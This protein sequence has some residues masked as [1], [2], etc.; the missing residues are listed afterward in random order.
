MP[1]DT[2]NAPASNLTGAPPG[3]VDANGLSPT[4]MKRIWWRTIPLLG[5]AMMLNSIDRSNVSFA[6]L[7][8]NESLGFSSRV[9]GMGITI[10]FLAY[11]SMTLPGNLILLK[12]GARLWLGA[13]AIGWG[14]VSASTAFVSTAN[15]FYVNR[16]LLGL[17]EGGFQPGVIF[18]LTLWFPDRYRAG[19]MASFMM[20]PVITGIFGSP[21]SASLLEVQGLG[22]EGWQWLFLI[23]GLPSVLLGIAMLT[24]L[25]DKPETAGWM[26]PADRSALTRALEAD[27]RSDQS[28]KG[29]NAFRALMQPQIQLLALIYFLI[30]MAVWT[31][32][33]WMPQIIQ[34]LTG[35]GNIKT[36][37][38]SA[39][40]Y[41]VATPALLFIGR[42]SDRNG[43]RKWHLAGTLLVGAAGLFLTAFGGADWIVMAGL[44]LAAVGVFAFIGPFWSLLSA[45][46]PPETRAVVI[47]A[48]GLMGPLGGAIGPLL[49]GWLR[50]GTGSF[51]LAMIA[52]GVA[53]AAAAGCAL[54]ACRRSV[55]Q[56]RT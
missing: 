20:A 7:D 30:G 55:D 42:S 1:S 56:G 54:L 34:Q 28:V 37:A 15:E 9:F 14:T 52:C 45:L 31:V 36:G 35:S 29:G 41:L 32:V 46:V 10:F 50:A 6:A 51:G 53:M 18:Y 23:E 48:V 17:F 16:L 5:I 38:L 26:R 13:L 49:T 11:V 12:T 3:H 4:M 25:A 8:M 33:F 40:P 21:L 2:L 24:W 22:L 39:L 44:C 47:A 19:A 43:E 27:R